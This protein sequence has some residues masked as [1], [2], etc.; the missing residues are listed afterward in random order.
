MMSDIG[1]LTLRL[2]LGIMIL[3]HGFE[4]V[5]HG[6]KG[7][8]YLVVTAGL[9]EFFAYGVYIGELVLPILIIMGFYSRVASLLLAF[10]MVMAIFLAHYNSIFELGKHGAPVIE[11]PFLYF[12]ISV[13]VFML[14]SGRY[15]I[16]SK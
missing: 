8:K 9:P 15:A 16:N 13:V 7:V 5:I 1:R 2:T 3:F 6:I 14:G 12:I 11:L 4:K 10:N